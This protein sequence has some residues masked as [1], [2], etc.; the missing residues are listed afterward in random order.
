MYMNRSTAAVCCCLRRRSKAKLKGEIP[1][2]IPC[3][4]PFLGLD[5]ALMLEEIGL[6]LALARIWA[7][8]EIP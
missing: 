4:T 5:L 6:D 1:C 8:P 7:T 3:E 2:E